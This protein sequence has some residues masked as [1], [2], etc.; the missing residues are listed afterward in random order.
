MTENL[1]LVSLVFRGR[2]FQYEFTPLLNIIT[3]LILK[4]ESLQ[5][6][7]RNK[8]LFFLRVSITGQ[9]EENNIPCVEVNTPTYFFFHILT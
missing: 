9:T 1:L 3:L 8:I 5:Q 7:E 6:G 4:V 2:I